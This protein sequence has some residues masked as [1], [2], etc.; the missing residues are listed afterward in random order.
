MFTKQVLTLTI[1]IVTISLAQSQ[2]HNA[3]FGYRVAG[4]RLL[5]STIQHR[6][7]TTLG[8]VK[9]DVPFPPEGHTNSAIITFINV[10]DQYLDDNG[11]Y[12][13][14][15][16]GGVNYNHTTVHLT[17]QRGHCFN[18]QIDIYGM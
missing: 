15:L 14:L 3:Q 16:E 10:T 5:Y 13:T 17:S 18:F 11:G 9:K 1:L 7:F 8:I 6:E 2:S 4:D 12:A